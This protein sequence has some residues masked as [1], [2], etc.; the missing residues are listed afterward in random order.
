MPDFGALDSLML[1]LHGEFV[2]IYYL[3]LPVFFALSIALNWFRFPAGGPDFIDTLR[4]TIISTLLLAALPELSQAILFIADGIAE[5][6]D[7]ARGLD[8][9]MDLARERSLGQTKLT[10]SLL[11]IPNLILSTLAFLSFLLLFLARYL[12]IAMYHFY[13]LFYMVTSPL[14]LL[15][16]LFPSTSQMTGNLFRSL[17]EVASWKI[18]WAILGAM[19]AA[20]GFGEK[21]QSIDNYITLFVMNVVIAYSMLKT[22]ALVKSLTSGGAHG[23]AGEIGAAAATAISMTIPTKG[24]ASAK[25]G[26]SAGKAAKDWTNNRIATERNR[27]SKGGINY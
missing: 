25:K 27:R 13:W 11:A 1:Q 4:R 19:L 8:S 9:F 20:T 7:Q 17:A 22:P 21:Y 2:R 18:V 5:R 26:W 6:I 23:M 24:L 16:N 10:M 14:L 15:M 3:L 12:T